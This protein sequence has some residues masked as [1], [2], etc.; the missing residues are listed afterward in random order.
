VDHRIPVLHCYLNGISS[1]DASS[2]N[3]VI[4]ILKYVNSVKAQS[5]E[6]SFISI[7]EKIRK[8]FINEG[9]KSK[10]IE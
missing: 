6:D 7:V 5:L 1:K 2:I 9:Y 3:N 4:F 10:K 8:V